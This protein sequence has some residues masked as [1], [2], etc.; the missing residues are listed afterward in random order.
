M[1]EYSTKSIGSN[2]AQVQDF[3]IAEEPMARLVLRAQIH[4]KGVRGRLIRQRRLS[5]DDSWEDDSPIDIR[6]LEKGEAFN[7][8]LKTAV[9]EKLY[10]VITSL[11]GHVDT[12]GIDH[13]VNRYKTV[14]SNEIVVDSKN[15]KQ[16]I[17]QLVSGNHTIDVL[18]AFAEDEDIDLQAFADAEQVKV[19]RKEKEELVDRLMGATNYPEV[20]GSDSWQKFILNKN[21]MFG[22][23]YLDPIDRAKINISGIMPDFIYPTADGFADILEIKLPSDGVIIE[24]KNHRGSWKWT[25]DTSSAIGQITNYILEIERQRYEIEKNI[26][27]ET[28]RDVLLLRPRAFILTGNSKDWASPKK[29][30]LRKLNSVLHGI[31]V[32]TYNDLVLRAERIIQ[33]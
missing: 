14:K 9:I 25:A 32:I 11:K 33:S 5:K 13:G 16:I 26:K 19:M 22:A 29:E 23:K 10:Q 30:A 31:E 3:I 4:N 12:R 18:R 28:G 20:H 21:W 8:E 6:S 7:V 15:L 1:N 17:E 2:I 24:D 27:T